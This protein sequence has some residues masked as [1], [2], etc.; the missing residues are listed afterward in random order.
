M[1]CPF[2]SCDPSCKR[3]TPFLE[4]KGK[5]NEIKQ[6][7]PARSWLWLKL[8]FGTELGKTLGWVDTV[9]GVL[10]NESAFKKRDFREKNSFVGIVCLVMAFGHGAENDHYSRCFSRR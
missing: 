3:L 4:G 9:T 7:R 5:S 1:S 8:R 6:T 10:N 2:V